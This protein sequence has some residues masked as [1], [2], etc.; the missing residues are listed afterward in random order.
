D[1]EGNEIHTTFYM[2]FSTIIYI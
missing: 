2:L 1:K